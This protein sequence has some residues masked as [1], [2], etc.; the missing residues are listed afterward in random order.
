MRSIGSIGGDFYSPINRAGVH[1]HNFAVEFEQ[2]LSGDAEIL[3]VLAQAWEVF[4]V[5]P[6]E[7]NP[8]YVGYV[9][10]AKGVAY[11]VA[12]FHAQFA[13][14]FGN[15]GRRTANPHFCAE[16]QETKNV[17]ECHA[18]VQDVTNDG[19]F[20]ASHFTESFPDGKGVEQGLGGVFVGA[21]A[22]I[23]N[24]G[25]DTARKI[26]AGARSGVAHYH[27]VHLH[28][29]DVV[30][31]VEQGFTFAHAAAAGG[32]IDRIGA[33]AAFGQFKRNAGAGTAFKK[34]V[35]YRNITQGRDFFDRAVDDF[36]EIIS[37]FEDELNVV[38]GDVFDADQVAC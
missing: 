5:L 10:P 7:L 20:F 22:S 2:H 19:N 12:D 31:R 30:H 28:G 4:D 32:K 6:F 23:Y 17:A 16:F 14:M 27:H 35:G 1:H 34:E 8:K 38:F 33:E 11:V 37:R 29:E 15:Q 26:D 21:V 25:W 18:A 13:V 24:I 9:A 3:V 36:F